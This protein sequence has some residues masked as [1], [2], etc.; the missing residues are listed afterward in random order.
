[1]LSVGEAFR[2]WTVISLACFAV[3]W[4]G[5]L[6]AV[7]LPAWV[8]L[9]LTAAVPLFEPF[10][11]NIKGQS[12]H[13]LFS[14][15]ALSAAYGVNAWALGSVAAGG[16]RRRQV[17]GG[18][19][20]GLAAALKLYYGLVMA[21]PALVRRQWTLLGSAG[22]VFGVTAVAT[23]LAWGTGIWERAI[24]LSLTWR[25]RPETIHTAYQTTHS[26]TSRL[27]RFDEQWNPAP[28]TDLPW[29][30]ESLWWLI[31]LST[32]GLTVLAL[33]R[34]R[35]WT[36]SL[37]PAWS[38]LG[39][40]VVVPLASAL[41]PIGEGYHHALC[42]FPVVVVTAILYEAWRTPS[43][44][45]ARRSLP[46]PR[47]GISAGLALAVALLGAPWQYNVARADGWANLLHYP[48]LYGALVLWLLAVVL[49]LRPNLARSMEQARA[50]VTSEAAP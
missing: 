20:L 35:R 50:G 7:R 14:L 23:F 24:Y 29:L 28:V 6:R 36:T 46:R 48:R 13:V 41:A 31:A 49:L 45:G 30:A 9:L 22:L 33:W 21:V 34:S 37:T 39:P 18:V 1:L 3:G 43:T 17:L 4:L 26:V 38:L 27:F 10:A 40:C 12:Y 32:V 2:V 19:L 47:I 11:Q 5:L 25:A 42:L 8:G 15:A 44:A 16:A